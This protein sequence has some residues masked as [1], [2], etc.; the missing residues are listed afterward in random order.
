[1]SRLLKRCLLIGWLLI[2]GSCLVLAQPPASPQSLGWGPFNLAEEAKAATIP[3]VKKYLEDMSQTTDEVVT[4]A[5]KVYRTA[6]IPR[7]YDPKEGKQL[8]FTPIEGQ[9]LTLEASQIREVTH[10]EQRVLEKTR[11]FLEKRLDTPGTPTPLSRFLQLRTAE[12]VLTEAFRYHQSLRSQG[13]RDS[14]TWSGM[15]TELKNKLFAIRIDELRALTAERDYVTAEALSQKMFQSAPGDRVL[16]DVIE[17]FYIKMCDDHFGENNTLQ[18]RLTLEKLRDRYR[19]P[20]TSMSTRRIIER[21]EEEARKN[22]EKSRAAVEE[23]NRSG[24]LA[25]L[26]AA[27]QA[28]PTL[29]GLREFRVKLLGEFSVLRVGVRTLPAVMSPLTAITDADKMACRLLYEPLVG[30]R[31]AP[32]GSDGYFTSLTESPRR[33]A[34]GWEFVLPTGLKWSDGSPVKSD[35]ILRSYEFISQPGTPAFNP[36]LDNDGLFVVNQ[37]DETRFTITFK[38]P[39]LDPLAFLNFPILPSSR[40]P[41]D[42]SSSAAATAFAK[43]PLGTGPYMFASAEGDEVIFKVNPHYQR[44]SAPQG[45]A[46]KEIRFIK[47]SDWGVAH[48]ALLDGRW[49]MLLDA[50][51][52]EMDEITGNPQAV[53]FTPTE[54]RAADGSATPKLTNPRI[55][56]LGFNYRKPH[57]QKKEAREAISMAINRDDII[58]KIFRGKTRTN[59]ASLNGPFPLNSWAYDTASFGQSAYGS[60]QAAAK[61]R[62]AGRIPDLKLAVLAEDMHGIQACNMIAADLKKIGI[63]C[64]VVPTPANTLFVDMYKPVPEFDL[65]YTTWDYGNESLNLRPLVDVTA[66]N[67]AGA[68]Y[69]GY[70]VSPAPQDPT[71]MRYLSN[72]LNNRELEN[73]RRQMYSIHKHMNDNAVIA[74]LYQLDKHIAVHRS[75]DQYE[76]FHPVYVF[77]GVEKWV[78]KSGGQ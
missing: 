2:A 19:N 32:S 10:Y 65:L 27:E 29:P 59:H 38:A 57:F 78:I 75:L 61:A 51:S 24:A 7:K 26:E 28:W 53:V 25:S 71:L 54:T 41:R 62:A 18:A 21:L 48:K 43:N 3:E 74:P 14:A 9:R 1:M 39:V 37:I 46:I 40:L 76:R 52:K 17:Q 72:S 42:Q 36:S 47:Y 13:T 64:T 44:A 33:I 35:D 63:N 69:M 77:D 66:A 34:K 15:D 68:N 6:P 11:Q 12:M 67:G 4:T 8:D 60:V 56:Y 22:F 45:P 50:T 70:Q 16:L 58:E 20:W 49:Q 5:G 30:A 23:K 73:A 55:Y 31:H